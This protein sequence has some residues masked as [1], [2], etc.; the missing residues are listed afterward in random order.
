M[1]D[2]F[3]RVRARDS[4]LTDWSFIEVLRI[5]WVVLVTTFDEDVGIVVLYKLFFVPTIGGKSSELLTDDYYYCNNIS[6][7]S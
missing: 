5:W 2:E 4:D 1:L 7:C 3:Y 6:C